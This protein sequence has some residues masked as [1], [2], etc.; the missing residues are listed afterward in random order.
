MVGL[1]RLMDLLDAYG[2]KATF[3]WVAELAVEHA[4]FVRNLSEAGHEIG[5]HS[6][7][8]SEMLYDQTPDIFMRETREALELI[9]NVAGRKIRAYR[10]PCF[11]ITQ[12]TSWAFDV[13][14]ELG[15]DYD[16]SVFPVKNWRYGIP[17]FSL[18]PVRVGA[19]KKL[20][21]APLSVRQV[22]HFN[23]P[24]TGGAYFRIY[25]YQI[26]AANFHAIA[27]CGRFAI[28]YIHPW[29]LDPDHPKVKV[30]WRAKLTHYMNLGQTKTKLNRL[31]KDFSFGPL[32]AVM[33]ESRSARE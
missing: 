2:V 10:A 24:A 16:S 14:S 21:E 8:H 32:G 20:W 28:F 15:V 33:E 5:C 17:K 29:E 26:S 22:G 6:L 13:L 11:S 27:A 1:E 31:L 12:S 18:I 25:P 23:I 30:H 9:G 7:R 3:F 4:G 19:E